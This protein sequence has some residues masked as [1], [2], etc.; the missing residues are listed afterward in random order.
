MYVSKSQFQMKL[1]HEA[2]LTRKKCCLMIQTFYKR[3]LNRRHFRE[4]MAILKH[5]VNTIIKYTRVVIA[6]LIYKKK[7]SAKKI[8]VW[9]RRVHKQQHISFV[10]STY[11]QLIGILVSKIHRRIQKYILYGWWKTWCTKTRLISEC[12]IL[13][14]RQKKKVYR[15]GFS[16]QS[17]NKL[18]SDGKSKNKGKEQKIEL[19]DNNDMEET[20]GNNYQEADY[21]KKYRRE[22]LE[23]YQTQL[24][25]SNDVVYGRWYS[26]SQLKVMRSSV[27]SVPPFRRLDPFESS[28][29][30]RHD[31][32]RIIVKKWKEIGC[33]LHLEDQKSITKTFEPNQDGYINYGTFVKFAKDQERPCETHSRIVCTKS[34]VRANSDWPMNAAKSSYCQRCFP[35][36]C[37]RH[38]PSFNCGTY[39]SSRVNLPKPN[40][41]HKYEAGKIPC[42]EDLRKILRKKWKPDLLFNLPD[43][44]GEN[45]PYESAINAHTESA[46][47]TKKMIKMMKDTATVNGMLKN[48]DVERTKEEFED[49]ILS[50]KVDERAMANMNYCAGEKKDFVA[51]TMLLPDNLQTIHSDYEDNLIDNQFPKILQRIIGEAL[52]PCNNKN[53]C[54][55]CPIRGCNKIFP[56]DTKIKK[57]LKNQHTPSD[58][59]SCLGITQE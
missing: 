49:A 20:M 13:N 14:E 18:P 9:L 36:S 44:K 57:H 38:N 58:I 54:I 53:N 45:N 5:A 25:A 28:I 15:H 39:R 51:L 26:T 3:C 27:F 21:L 41:T 50:R 19:N 8:E 12:G 23:D 30:H 37:S 29:L 10:K 7:R 48:C 47:K 32:V 2:Y 4:N 31:F 52:K 40:H 6:K 55:I 11:A 59:K 16:F 46:P 35:I 22:I 17:S 33:T 1:K 24:C 56:S 43:R 34:K 42:S